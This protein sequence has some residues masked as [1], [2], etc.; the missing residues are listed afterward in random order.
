MLAAFF[1]ALRVEANAGPPYYTD[2]QIAAEPSGLAGIA[3]SR[4]ALDIDMR[5]LFPNPRA[6]HEQVDSPEIRNPIVVSA[7][8]S[9][10]N[11][12]PAREVGLV[13]A[14]GAPS[15]AAFSVTLDGQPV[16]ALPAADVTV[17]E[18]WQPPATTP[19]L[20]GSDLRY[21]EPPVGLTG[22]EGTVSWGHSP[23]TFARSTTATYAFTVTI[24]AGESVLAVKY[25]A[26][27]Q[28]YRSGGY[29]DNLNSFQF[30]Y[31][32]APARAWDGFGGLDVTV[33]LPSCWQAAS[34]PRLTRV[35]DELRGSFESVPADAL[36]LTVAPCDAARPTVTVC[37][38]FGLILPLGA[39][40]IVLG[41]RARRST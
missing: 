41:R 20:E 36:A 8:Y 38:T 5:D 16:A 29:T 32:L 2:G 35:G 37:G 10:T 13:F 22:V 12:G 25:H 3:I 6:T 15:T 30:A 4:E 9:L 27:P 39:L 11:R 26:E 40:G 1:A 31:V 24:P 19:G 28:Q 21:L 14:S 17:P 18:A 33:R 7:V 23:Q 34:R